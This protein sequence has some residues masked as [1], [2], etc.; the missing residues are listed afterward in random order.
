[1]CALPT[2]TPKV[3]GDLGSVDHLLWQDGHRHP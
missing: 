3:S 1:M 2:K